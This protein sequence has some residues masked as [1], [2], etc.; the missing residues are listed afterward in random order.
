MKTKNVVTIG[1]GTGS[2]MLLSGLKKYPI[3]IAAIVSM[4][5]DGGSTGVLRDELGVLPPGDVRQ[6]LV[7]LSES[8]GA[9][10]ELMSYRF[11]GGGL[12]GHSFGNLLLSALE[13]ING[14]FAK[15]VEEAAKILNVKGDVIPVTEESTNLYMKL[16]NGKVLKGEEQINHNFEIERA[17]ISR[18]YLYPKAKANPKAIKKIK[19]ADLIII[20]PGNHYCSIIP[21]FLVSG[22]PEA[23]R[24]SKAKVVFN[25]NL[26]NKKGHTEKFSLNNYVDSIGKYIG[27]DRIDFITFNSKKPSESLI[28]KYESKKELLIKFDPDESKKGRFKVIQADILSNIKPQYSKN[29]V[30]AAHRAFIRH[31]STKLARILMMIMELGEHENIIKQII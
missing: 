31:D 29:D 20:G 28:K 27:K 8:S 18:N 6:C 13:K 30:L 14:D 2:F 24:K 4:A 10:R 16:K 11:D 5:D 17:G 12:K 25:C 26:V 23:I 1:G 3:N 15:G 22:I 21:N 9:L 7:A 19:E